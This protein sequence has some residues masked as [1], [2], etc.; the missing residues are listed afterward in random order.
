M[1]KTAAIAIDVV[2]FVILL[3]CMM[4]AVILAAG[5]LE[6][7]SGWNICFTKA[8]GIVIAL[9]IL[10]GAIWS[11]HVWPRKR[12]GATP[13]QS[14]VMAPAEGQKPR[15]AFYWY[16]RVL[17]VLLF[18]YILTWII[19]AAVF[20]S[21][22]ERQRSVLETIGVPRDW[23]QVFPVYRSDSNAATYLDNG[24]DTLAGLKLRPVGKWFTATIEAPDSIRTLAPKIDSLLALNQDALAQADQGL[25][26]DKLVWRDYRGASIDTFYQIRFPNYMRL[27]ELTK[28]YL[29]A[30]ETAA[31]RKDWKSAQE[32]CQRAVRLIDLMRQDPVLIG[33]MI[34]I[35]SQGTIC[36]GLTVIA[37]NGR[38][39]P[40]S[41]ALVRR[42]CD[43]LPSLA[44][45][46]R[47]GMVAEFAS[48]TAMMG[49]M[50]KK[51]GAR[52]T[53]LLMGGIEGKNAAAV[54]AIVA[55]VYRVWAG[56]DLY[57]ALK[58]AEYVVRI[59]SPENDVAAVDTLQSEYKR[60][61]KKRLRLPALFSSISAPNFITMHQRELEA[62]A[63]PGA[64][65]LFAAA[66]E[67]Q[68][69]RGTYPRDLEQLVPQYFKELPVSPINGNEY[70]YAR[71]ADTLRVS[72]PGSD[73]GP[74]P[75]TTFILQK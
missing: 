33:K 61:A 59:S 4:V 53:V 71:S 29:L 43:A 17:G 75:K 72:T 52:K 50:A 11:Y 37:K 18:A 65:A 35:V 48:S 12:F 41:Y 8:G 58:T 62:R 70:Q 67:Y 20:G 9:L 49:A 15:R 10:G 32:Q 66:L 19:S 34:A 57:C 63:K 24:T 30:A 28:M 64:V 6:I 26:C 68:R 42:T 39:D 16:C 73:G 69:S 25:A 45:Q 60:F 7:V 47:Q 27:Q 21:L 1:K 51:L 13:G 14:L 38:N 2:L 22:V 23:R 31:Y 55:P 54:M 40:R 36:D 46:V 56:W 5:F 44:G 3:F 74:V